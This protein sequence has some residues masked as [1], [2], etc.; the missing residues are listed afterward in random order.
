MRG[1][2]KGV[3]LA[4][5]AAVVA[6][7]AS[8]AANAATSDARWPG[9]LDRIRQQPW[10]WVAGLAAVAVLVAVAMAWRQ[11]RGPGATGDQPPPSVQPVPDWVVDR[12]ERART[13]KA[14]CRGRTV[15]ITTSLEGAGGFGKTVLARA[16][17]AS[18]RVRRRFRGRVYTVTIGRD[19]RGRAAIAAKVAEAT[20]FIT[21]DT[22]AFD[23]PG[24]AGD[25]L[26]RLLDQ[27]PRTLLLIDDVWD[28]EQLE[29]FLRGG[30]R[31]VRLVTTRVPGALPRGTERVRVDQM[32]PDQ[33][34]AVLTWEL[35]ALP[36]T[37]V[38]DLLEA[39]GRWA[40]LLRLTN[41]LITRRTSTGTDP[42]EAA[43][44]A[45]RDLGAH[46]PAAVDGD[47]AP[48]DLDDP[49]RRAQAV[50]ATVEAARTL[51]PPGGARRLAELAVF[52][53]DESIPVPLVARL[54]A[55]TGGL[56]EAEARSLCVEFDR[57]SLVSLTPGHGGR[58]TLHDVLRDYLHKELGDP[59]ATALHG[60]LADTW[61]RTP[62]NP[63]DD[64]RGYVLDHAIEHLLA[65]GRTQDAERVATDLR[66][67]ET[68]LHQRGPMA[69]WADLFDVPTGMAAG[70]ADDL[71]RAAHLL[72]PTDPP[73]LLTDVLHGRLEWLPLW[74]G[75]IAARRLD[76]AFASRPLLIHRS[77]PPDLPEPA[78]LRT[79][80]GHTGPVWSVGVTPDGTSLV[81]VGADGMARGLDPDSGGE[82]AL[83][84]RGGRFRVLAVAPNGTRLA[85][86][87]TGR[88][89]HTWSP[90]RATPPVRTLGPVGG[91]RAS[92]RAL[93]ISGSCIATV[94]TD[95]TL[96]FWDARSGNH[97]AQ[98]V[99]ERGDEYTC[100]AFAPGGGWLA[101]GGRRHVTLM[102]SDLARVERRGLTA[103]APVNAIAIARDGSWMVTAE[104][105]GV[106][107]I[108]DETPP[109]RTSQI[110]AHS[111]PATAVA[112][113]PD[114]T[115]LVSGGEDGSVAVWD[116]TTGACRAR[117]SAHQG[118]VHAVAVTP[119]GDQLVSAGEDG[120]VRVW[121]SRELARPAS[122]DGGGMR[123]VT[124]VG[125]AGRLAV[126]HT[127]GRTRLCDAEGEDWSSPLA[128]LDGEHDGPVAF[129]PHGRWCA[130][131]VRD[132]YGVRIMTT[133]GQLGPTGVSV[134]DLDIG[135]GT[136]AHALAVA[137]DG[138]WLAVADSEGSLQ[139]W[140]CFPERRTA[141]LPGPRA[142]AGRAEAVV[143]ARDGSWVAVLRRGPSRATGD[144]S[145]VHVVHLAAD[146]T[147]ATRQVEI[148]SGERLTALAP[149]PDG[150]RLLTASSTGTVSHWD[151]RTG[152]LLA[153]L[154]DPGGPV[155]GLS[156]SPD[157]K[158][159]ATAGAML[160]VWDA[161]SG[162]TVTGV[163]AETPFASCAWLPDGRGLVAVGER[164]LYVYEFRA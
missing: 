164:G 126:G 21:G 161:A 27:R 81:T 149:T 36:E 3:S 127:D 14:V 78:L 160:R 96:E 84:V 112:V 71:T 75:L 101:A 154:T 131:V 40:L 116:R 92:V 156:V 55:A 103:G 69:A 128:S 60:T 62:W 155:D 61:G 152:A 134:A 51:L 22:T 133:A 1:V 23:D 91:R 42:A 10:W 125:D 77:T 19:V 72:T 142:T 140:D 108:W 7:L 79:F 24:L 87:G 85:T 94:A 97:L 163:R 38:R 98:V 50:R 104:A 147:A 25:H 46:G 122:R 113:S 5:I 15:A 107:Q 29:P 111:G 153:S 119:Y 57:L 137:P 93:A 102:S 49:A 145:L 121:D 63:G 26:G 70:M 132:G 99:P 9:A 100:V 80:L 138:T 39:T 135:V 33:A 28:A 17:A 109:L 136:S 47:T 76:P 120:A 35:P 48:F 139:L 6:V 105:N 95:G 2:V 45:L 162:R 86:G 20:R 34:R 117:Y 82:F 41:R 66:W 67:I 16:V 110:S 114:G 31:C 159:I 52:A 59:A 32:T 106:L 37:L 68:R 146:R 151:P 73:E 43:A 56:T 12:A 158:W 89:F 123:T 11:E 83:D 141:A 144:A 118:A 90:D 74:S 8:L 4:G 18:P 148:H 44:E 54:W 88:T 157:G 115:W 124:V 53:E 13:V 58:V 143:V 30:A 150:T 129:A 130:A 64:V 65:A